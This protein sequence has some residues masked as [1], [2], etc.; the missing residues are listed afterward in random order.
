MMV[1]LGPDVDAQRIAAVVALVISVG[2]D[3]GVDD[4]RL[5]MREVT[6]VDSNL[7][8]ALHDA[9][10]RCDGE[11]IE[12]CLSRPLPQAREVLAAAELKHLIEGF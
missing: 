3:L 5:D 12:M 7:V 6:R 8:R 2:A 9:A 10:R 11:G 4:V 1:F